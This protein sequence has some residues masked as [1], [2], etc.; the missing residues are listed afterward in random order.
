MWQFSDLNHSYLG[1]QDTFISQALAQ[2]QG[3]FSNVREEASR[4]L[5]GI[6]RVLMFEKPLVHPDLHLH[7]VGHPMDECFWL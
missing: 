5:V 1:T 7:W 4:N 6:L 2:F 3:V